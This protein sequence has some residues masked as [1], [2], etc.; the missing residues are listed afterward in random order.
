MIACPSYAARPISVGGIPLAESPLTIN[1]HLIAFI[2]IACSI[3]IAWLC[4]GRRTSMLV[5]LCFPG[6]PTPQPTDPML[7]A[8]DIQGISSHFSLGPWNWPFSW[9]WRPWPCELKI[10]LGR[11]DQLVLRAGDRSFTFGPVQKWWN[12]PAK[13]QYQF[14]PASGDVVSFTREIGR[15]PWLTPFTFNIMGGSVPKAKRCVYDHLRWTKDSGSALE[16]T[17]RNEFW[18]YPRSGWADTCNNRLSR[19][20]IRPSPIEKAAADY[21]KSSKGWSANEYRL[22][23]GSTTSE[24]TIVNVIYLKDESAG[25]HPARAN[26]S[27]CE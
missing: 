27:C 14:V 4:L 21:L 22:E 13:P 25:T 24:D 5:D 7:I 16:I 10:I 19:V 18:W 23:A 12:D 15:L 11:Q 26:R 8:F 9:P 1:M 3:P 20:R 6:R 2:F 17:W